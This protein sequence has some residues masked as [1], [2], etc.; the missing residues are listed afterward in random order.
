MPLRF[1][2]SGEPTPI[3]ALGP[4]V[5]SPQAL[6]Q[7]AAFR[8]FCGAVPPTLTVRDQV[9]IVVAER[10]VEQQLAPGVRVREQLLADEFGISKAPVSEA[11]MR[12][13]HFGLVQSSAR[14]GV[15]VSK[16]SVADYEDLVDYRFTLARTFVPRFIERQT[17]SDQDVLQRYIA[18]M[19][20]LVANDAKA[21]EFIELSDRCLL[22]VAM[23]AGSQR[24]AQAMC[25][26][27]LQL[28]RYFAMAARTVKQRRLF[29]TRWQEASKIMAARNATQ[30]LVHF[31]Q[32]A[33]IRGTD[34]RNAIRDAQ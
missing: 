2:L 4:F 21:F 29:L 31:E 7:P 18:Q 17:Q 12:L 15:F 13:E 30:A 26:I 19:T 3:E 27:S 22:F 34:V 8:L 25:S 10:V 32:T 11:L 5:S 6:A 14:R 1:L 23:Q 20:Q 28:L 9:G 33:Q 16:I 24:I